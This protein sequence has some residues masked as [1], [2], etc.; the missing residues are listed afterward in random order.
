M[1]QKMRLYLAL[2]L[3]LLC[4]TLSEAKKASEAS[5]YPSAADQQAFTERFWSAVDGGDR[6]FS[7]F[8]S[9]V[10]SKGTLEEVRMLGNLKNGKAADGSE[11]K[12]FR[13]DANDEGPMDMSDWVVETDAD[14]NLTGF[15]EKDFEEMDADDDGKISDQERADW[16]AQ[17]KKQ[18]DE[19]GG[20]PGEVDNPPDWDQ[21]RD[22]KPDPGFALDC[23]Q[24]VKG[25][26]KSGCQD[27][28][29][30]ACPGTCQTATQSCQ[31]HTETVEGKEVPCHTCFPKE[32]VLLGC[33]QWGLSND[34]NCNGQCT[35]GP[36]A[37]VDVDKV[38][39]QIV[40]TMQT[41]VKGSTQICYACM[42]ATE[43]TIEYYVLIIETPY[44]RYVL[45]EG[46]LLGQFMPS[47]VMALANVNSPAAFLKQI[48]GL[49]GVSALKRM[50]VQ[51]LG[52]LLQQGM[53]SGGKFNQDC[54]NDFKNSELPKAQ[55]APATT[56]KGAKSVPSVAAGEFG[57]DP[58]SRVTAEGPV[59][60]CGNVKGE[61]A[62]MI[63]DAGGNVIR[64][65][66]KNE[67]AK[68]PNLFTETLMKA[69]QL[70]QKVME[71]RREGWQG[72]LKKA[73]KSVVKT[74]YD[75]VAKKVMRTAT[76]DGPDDPYFTNEKGQKKVEQKKRSQPNIVI[77]SSM[78]MGGQVLG[79]GDVR[80][81]K[82]SKEKET[83]DQWGLKRIGF[84]PYKDPNSAW[85]LVDASTPNVLVA[86]IDSGL[87]MNHPDAP[88][89]VWQNP[90]EI[91][92]NGIDD[93][94]NSYIDDI[95][96]WNFVED[97]ND[98][99]DFK[100][101]GTFVAGIIAAQRD[102]GIGIAGIN[103]G[104]I[105]LPLR[106]ANADGEASS[107]HVYRAIN[108]A[109]A[110]GAQVI[111]ISLGSRGLSRLEQA[112]VNHAKELGAFVVVASGNVNEDIQSHG[113][114]AVP[115]VFAVGSIDVEGTRS[116][117]SNWGANNGIL[118]PGDK[119]YSLYSQD[120]KG[121]MLASIKKAGVFPQSG[122]SFSAPMVAATA[123]LLLAKDPNL[124][125]T[126][127]E[128]IL[129]RS[130]EEMYEV[131]WDDKSGAGVLDAT[132]ALRGDQLRELTVSITGIKEGSLDG[133]RADALDI[134]ATVRGPVKEFV[135]ELG[136][137]KNPGRFDRIGGPYS[138]EATD[139]WVA[140]INKENLRTSK[141]WVVKITATDQQGKELTAQ[142]QLEA[143]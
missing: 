71:F 48:E 13:G 94:G 102:N 31:Q 23:Y 115:G 53:A 34:A 5:S 76:E 139:D 35:N 63:L 140:R 143:K 17:K 137:G 27:G 93:D 75:E 26:E 24:C 86:V 141:D 119:I 41:R 33:E 100:G 95:N 21:N 46:G 138:L 82:E 91:A 134:F 98:L 42:N 61:K 16:D 2:S 49:A 136:R 69:D 124:T 121:E 45:G 120:T 18:H 73:G 64:T 126:Q 55:A 122:T 68:N 111:N 22:G 79:G 81:Q 83:V 78:K 57:Q 40:P 109:V 105:I 10:T 77:G 96:G 117:I 3:L 38:S 4:P 104:A 70:S 123:S 103:P 19:A 15:K 97:N 56:G 130:A 72:L 125:A 87:D 116:T 84:L 92:G 106:V 107:F 54:F 67:A 58:A 60:A 62:M 7:D 90:N 8:S 114:S 30:G 39:G 132:A 44:V 1:I 74:L 99:R 65:I 20:A 50:N 80:E 9:D 11:A 89:F 12:G 36:C 113:P 127:I 66:L 32:S 37:P 110:Q 131:G 43:V 133:K 29:N 101:H 28:I 51:E 108:Y 14:G 59:V 142:T 129:H 47:S 52:N 88:A 135:V 118:A 112:A 6:A 128:D 85:H 25:Q